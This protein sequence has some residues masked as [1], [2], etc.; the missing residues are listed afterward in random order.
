MYTYVSDYEGVVSD[1]NIFKE[2]KKKRYDTPLKT[3]K[4]FTINKS[5][6]LGIV[7]DICLFYSYILFHKV[8]DVSSTRLLLDD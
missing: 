8:D 2:K 6:V 7:I 3:R 4:K 5:N 1:G